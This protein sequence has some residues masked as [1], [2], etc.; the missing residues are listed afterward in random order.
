MSNP[1][2]ID[3]VRAAPR[4]INQAWINNRG[5]IESRLSREIQKNVIE[6]SMT[7]VDAGISELFREEF[8]NL[9]FDHH[10]GLIGYWY[11]PEAHIPSAK[12]EKG[13]FSWLD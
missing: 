7:V 1:V 4:R 12:W 6:E 11:L 13:V 8:P 3:A 10:R 5:K 2:E 9:G